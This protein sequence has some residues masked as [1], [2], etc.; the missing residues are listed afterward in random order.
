ME[1][2]KLQGF[3][4]SKLLYR[5]SLISGE[6]DGTLSL[7]EIRISICS[8]LKK[9]KIFSVMKMERLTNFNKY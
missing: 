8:H 7:R 5:P 3:H 2:V 4:S 9:S 6:K 1:G